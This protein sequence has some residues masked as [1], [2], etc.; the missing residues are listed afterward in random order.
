[1]RRT[2]LWPA[3]F[4]TMEPV[5]APRYLRLLRRSPFLVKQARTLLAGK[6][7]G[8]NGPHVRILCAVA[9]GDE[10]DAIERAL[11]GTKPL[12]LFQETP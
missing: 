10:L 1:M 3:R 7:L 2:R 11:A 5:S 12:S 9:N 4:Q 6:V 8:G